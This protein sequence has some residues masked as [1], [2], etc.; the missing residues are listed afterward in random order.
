[1]LQFH[2]IQLVSPDNESRYRLVMTVQT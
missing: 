2:I 1:V